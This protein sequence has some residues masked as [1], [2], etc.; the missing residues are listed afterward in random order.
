MWN[1]AAAV[2]WKRLCLSRKQGHTRVPS[3]FPNPLAG[4][5]GCPSRSSFSQEHA[6]K[7]SGSLAEGCDVPFRLAENIQCCSRLTC[8]FPIFQAPT[9]PLSHVVPPAPGRA[10]QL[11]SLFCQSCID[12]GKRHSR[13][14]K[15]LVLLFLCYEKSYWVLSVTIPSSSLQKKTPKQNPNKKKPKTMA[16]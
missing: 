11:Q 12:W 4:L 1:T 3:V 14:F 10:S 7:C 13:N 8:S 5:P 15:R 16:K 9:D 6:F 2:N